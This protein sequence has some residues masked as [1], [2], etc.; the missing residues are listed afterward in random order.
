MKRVDRAESFFAGVLSFNQ[1][2]VRLP[3]VVLV[4]QK[5][6]IHP[7]RK[8]RGIVSNITSVSREHHFR[9]VSSSEWFDKEKRKIK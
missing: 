9:F 7:L 6:R 2:N 1:T 3:V 4:V 5:F 8:S